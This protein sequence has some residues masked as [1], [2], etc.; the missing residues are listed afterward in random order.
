MIEF[1]DTQMV[2]YYKGV[3]EGRK[4]RGGGIISKKEEK[5]GMMQ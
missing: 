1:M 2:E 5:I 4:K 3:E